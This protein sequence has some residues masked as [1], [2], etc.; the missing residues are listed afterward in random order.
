MQRP[1][2]QN[3]LVLALFESLTLFGY[4]RLVRAYRDE[5]AGRRQQTDNAY[6]Y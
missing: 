2:S 3:K 4:V 1:A 5:P 6:K